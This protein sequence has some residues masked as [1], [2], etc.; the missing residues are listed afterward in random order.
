MERST[1]NHRSRKCLIVFV[2]LACSIIIS[3]CSGSTGEE[4]TNYPRELNGKEQQTYSKIFHNNYLSKNAEFI[5]Y[6][7]ELPSS[8]F[9]AKGTIDW[10]NNLISMDVSLFEESEVDIS[11]T[12]TKEIAYETYAEINKGYEGES[13]T[14]RERV[15]RPV[16]SDKYATDSLGAA[17]FAL[18]TSTAENPLLLNQNGVRVWG[19]DKINDD[20]VTVYKGVDSRIYF[21]T[22]D[23]IMLRVK[24]ELQGFKQEVSIEFFNRGNATVALPSE[25]DTY[26]I[27]AVEAFYYSLRPNF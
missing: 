8:G 3:S 15:K 10:E 20:N 16:D 27:S 22:K 17:I 25:N 14:P 19:Q 21:V 23:A 2:V 24:G 12:Q 4:N 9:I 13:I 1:R 7:G 5:A 18:A 6:A 11:N 26:E